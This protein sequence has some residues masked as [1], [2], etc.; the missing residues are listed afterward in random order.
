MDERVVQFRVGLMV[1][2]TFI[3]LAI[4]ILLFGE[5]RSIWKGG[6]TILVQ[7]ADAPGVTENTPIKKSG[8]LIGRVTKVEL[9]EEGGV[10]VTA[11]IEEDKVLR[12]NEVCRITSSFLGDSVLHFVSS[13][14]KSLSASV[15]KPGETL[16]GT[17]YDDPIQVIANLQGRLS[18]AIGSVARTS[19]ELGSFVGRLNGM[20]KGNED[21]INR[22]VVQAEETTGLLQQAMRNTNEI[23][24]DTETRA[25]IKDSIQQAPQLLRDTRQAIAQMN[26]T[27]A[28][29][30][31]M[32]RNLDQFSGAMGEQG[33]VVFAQLASSAKKM[34]RLMD[35]LV[36]L[37]GTINSGKGTLGKLLNDP[38]LYQDLT[39]TANNVEELTRQ[40]RPILSDVRVFTD[41]IA[42][43]PEKLGVRGA[44]ERDQGTKY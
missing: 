12:H 25:K 32:I 29:A 36:L 27:F 44:M 13:D 5:S 41:K 30:D 10:L 33:Q 17:A 38:E 22:I 7:F 18:D 42:R 14:R 34:D 20:F 11:R 6:Y 16:Q 39:R 9:R 19:D 35:D 31:K 3:S 23:F 4:L 37:T 40:I 28:S 43:H 2:A 1:L 21:R 8:I 26:Q 24:S 15:V